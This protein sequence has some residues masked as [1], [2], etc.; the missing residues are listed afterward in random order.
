MNQI[1]VDGLEIVPLKEEE[2]CVD[3][4]KRAA[5]ISDRLKKCIQVR[6]GLC[7]CVHFASCCLYLYIANRAKKSRTELAWKS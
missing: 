5:D 4:V 1:D 7:L 6:S 2:V 3:L